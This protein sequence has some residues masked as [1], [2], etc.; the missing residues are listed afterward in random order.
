M[1]K[2]WDGALVYD[3]GNPQGFCMAPFQC[4]GRRS[5]PELSTPGIL[6]HVGPEDLDDVKFGTVDLRLSHV[7]PD[8]GKPEAGR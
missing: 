4:L 6:P 3:R 5:G 2:T 8:S 1:Y 7:S